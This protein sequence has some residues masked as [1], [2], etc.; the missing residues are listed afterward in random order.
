MSADAYRPTVDHV[1]LTRFNLPSQGA[2]SLI[3]AQD[4][5]LLE[6]VDLFERF[7][8]PSI[9]AQTV[10][11]FRWIVYFDPESPAWLLERLS[12]YVESGLFSA[13]YRESVTWQDVVVDARELTGGAAD[14]LITTNLDNDDAL[15][16][17]FVERVQ[18]EAAKGWRGALYMSTGL[19]LH[20]N[21]TYL[22]EDRDNAF[23]CA[24]EPWADAQTAWRDWHVMLGRHMKV[25]SI[26]GAPAW[27]QVIHGRNVSNRP[28]GQL[29][30][31]ARY[32]SLYPGALDDIATPTR[33]TLALDAFVHRPI[34]EVRE[35]VRFGGKTIML[36][37]FGKS[38]I[39]QASRL[40]QVV[41]L[42]LARFGGRS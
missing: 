19:I 14:L 11:H 18:R 10:T 40:T 25:R 32:Q 22:R 36:K 42:R 2:E 34:R 23:C 30:N 35:A 17:D 8:V 31:P 4:G 20:G 28:R 38:G 5:W 41:R 1:I 6:R 9:E 37:L 27:L 29:A 13:L 21:R 12:S 33:P 24:I 26:Q 7:T 16:T 3:R 15:A 39:E